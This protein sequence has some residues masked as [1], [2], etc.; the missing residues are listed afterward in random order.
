MRQAADSYGAALG[1]TLGIGN[2]DTDSYWEQT[3]LP[4]I[5]S[6][7]L[8]YALFGTNKGQPSKHDIHTP[9]PGGKGI[10]GFMRLYNDPKTLF[11]HDINGLYL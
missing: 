4:V 5:T 11:A 10:N 6:V 9:F 7:P 8:S 3:I 1:I 2:A